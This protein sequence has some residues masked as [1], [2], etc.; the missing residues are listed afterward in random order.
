[1]KILVPTDFSKLSKIAVHFALDLSKDFELDM[2]VLHVITTSTPAMARVSSKKLEETIKKSSERQMDELIA[3]IK[4]EHG[5]ELSIKAEIT[6]HSSIE[7]GVESFA[8]KN[9]IDLICIGTKGATGF[10]KLIFGSNAA[11]II[12]NSSVPVLTIPEYATYEGIDHILYSC[13]LENLE[14][15]LK[16]L[17]PYAKL[18]NAWIH[19]LH[20][21]KGAGDFVTDL[22]RQEDRLAALVSYDKLK[23]N[24]L[25]NDSIINGINQYATEIGAD[26]VAMFTRSTSLF[27][28]LFNKSITKTVA[29]QAK[30]PL[31][32][33]QKK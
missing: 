25:A 3:S 11:G 9:N 15:E 22:E 16:L 21:D 20:I 32:T 4:K 31:L 17:V 30:T 18:M 14:E 24:T 27:E 8:V 12:S 13:D 29:F 5:R 33:F 26:M 7:K 6:Y 1:M 10:K 28:N 23:T 19:I 2:V